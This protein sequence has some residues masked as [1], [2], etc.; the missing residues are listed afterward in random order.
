MAKLRIYPIGNGNFV[1]VRREYELKFQ[2]NLW[3]VL[4]WGVERPKTLGRF[5]TLTEA[6]RKVRELADQ[7]KAEVRK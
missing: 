2:A 6:R 7:R 5:P 4:E 3:Y 1:E